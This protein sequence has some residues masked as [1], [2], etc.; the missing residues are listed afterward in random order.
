MCLNHSICID[1][2]TLFLS[3]KIFYA[4][5]NTLFV[6]KLLYFRSFSNNFFDF[7]SGCF[8]STLKSVPKSPWFLQFSHKSRFVPQ[9]APHRTNTKKTKHLLMAISI[10]RFSWSSLEPITRFLIAGQ[11]LPQTKKTKHWLRLFATGLQG[12]EP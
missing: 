9:Y 1:L 3:E 8:Y 4:L 12:F 7:S 2:G 5:C 11:A 10:S 6:P